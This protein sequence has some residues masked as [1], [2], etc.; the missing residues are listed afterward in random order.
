[1]VF[2]RH[3]QSTGNKDG[4]FTGWIDVPLSKQGEQ[5]SREAGRMLKKLGYKF[6]K[7]YTSVLCRA[8]KTLDLILEEMDQ[9][10]DV[11]IVQNWRINER[12]YG[13]LQGHN[14]KVAAEEYGKMQIQKWRQGYHNPPPFI[15]FEDPKHPRFEDMYS[16]LSSEEQKQLPIGESLKMVRER[17]EPY[18]NDVIM[19]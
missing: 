13:A 11:D 12:H 3:G 14:K 1:M 2:V 5:E 6:D 4:T 15:D 7:A 8:T 10:N 16:G 18:W 19:P 17:V 9:E